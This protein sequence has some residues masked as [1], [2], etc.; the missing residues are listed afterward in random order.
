MRG[1]KQI[2]EEITKKD[3]KKTE[4]SG[5]KKIAANTQDNTHTHTQMSKASSISFSVG[6]NYTHLGRLGNYFHQIITKRCND[7]YEDGSSS[8]LLLHCPV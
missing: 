7:I 1:K 5:N 2:F 6:I 4:K 3:K 8:L